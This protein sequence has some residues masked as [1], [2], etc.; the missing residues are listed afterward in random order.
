MQHLHYKYP[1]YREH[2]ARSPAQPVF[3]CS[4][5][6]N[7]MQNRQKPSEMAWCSLVSGESHL[8]SRRA[9]GDPPYCSVYFAW[10]RRGTYIDVGAGR[11]ATAS[12][13]DGDETL[14]R[15]LAAALYLIIRAK[16]SPS[17]GTSGRLICWRSEG[18]ADWLEIGKSASTELHQGV[19]RPH[20]AV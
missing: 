14:L 2:S 17:L 18:S 15:R 11:A 8:V 4:S 20:S 12:P 1:T 7:T 6:V 19:Q 10:R 13:S 16:R 9:H 5:V 3:V